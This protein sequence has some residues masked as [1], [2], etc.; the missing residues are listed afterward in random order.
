MCGLCNEGAQKRLLSEAELSLAKAITIAQSM[1]AAEVESHSLKAEK[2]PIHQLESGG[3]SSKL[4]T[5]KSSSSPL[6]KACYRCGKN[7]H[8]ADNCYYK[9][10][11][12][13]KCKRKG[14]LA[15]VCRTKQP[16]LKDEARAQWMGRSPT[17]E[18]DLP[19]YSVSSHC[20]KPITVDIEING[21]K[22]CM[23]V[24]TGAAVSLMSQEVKEQLFPELKL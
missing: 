12:C 13:N 11:V 22:V 19:L 15:K 16:Q 18:D 2:M 3:K 20:T 24:D 23:E 4:G 17:P 7:D 14:H 6:R 21:T 5:P 8:V 1:E 10:A 9:E